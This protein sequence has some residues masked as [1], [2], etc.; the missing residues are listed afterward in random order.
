MKKIIFTLFIVFSIT[1]LS[2]AQI[3][4]DDYFTQKT[5][6]LDFIQAGDAGSSTLYFEQMKC[7]P[8]WGG[9][10]KNLI[11]KFNFGEY[12]FFVYD[13][14]TQK[15]IYSRGFSTLFQEW[16]TS[17]EAKTLSRSFYETI[18]FPFPKKTVKVEIHKRNRDGNLEKKFELLVNP[19]DY[20]IR[21]ETPPNFEYKKVLDNGEP[22]SKV[23][24]VII[25]DGY[26]K[27][28]MDKFTSDVQRFMGYFF[29]CSPY[30]ENKNNFNIWAINAISLESGPDIPGK[31]IYKN[32]VVSSSFYTFNTERYLMTYD[33]KSVRDIAGLVPYDQ[34]MILVN[35]PI[36]GGGGVFNYYSITSVDDSYSD[37][38]V[39]HEFGHA[40]GDLADEYWTSDVAVNDYFNLNVEPI[41]PNITTLVDFS[42]KWKNLVDK[43]VPIPTP[44]EKKYYGKVGAFE[45]GGYVEKGIYRPCFDCTMKSRSRDNFCPVCKN[46]LAEMI[47]FYCDK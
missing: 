21:E 40:F 30:K 28:E 1:T 35:S 20:F 36:Y 18:I 23:D 24:I 17:D 19:K 10:V 15:L 39:C 25:P 46:T 47:K 37:Y 12:R 42:S 29:D 26:T 6:R 14:T 8:Y 4:F 13:Y 16:Q 31:L 43:N 5:L 41:Q 27:D 45:G 22:K 2:F 11:D 9:N 33:I 38:V 3:N 44:N 32:T 34:I 7:E